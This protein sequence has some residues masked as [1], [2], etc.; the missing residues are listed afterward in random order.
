MV[1]TKQI[2]IAE[3]GRLHLYKRKGA[4]HIR[5]SVN[6]TGKIR[7][8]LPPWVP[9]SAG[10]AFAQQKSDWLKLQVR[11]RQLLRND[12]PVG[13]LHR[14]R[15]ELGTTLRSRVTDNEVI[16]KLP[17]GV[18]L[19]SD[20]AQQAA[21]KASIKA[22]KS[23]AETFLPRRLR[24][25]AA[26]HGFE[27]RSVEVKHLKSRWG[28]CSHR[29]EIVLNCFLMQ[30]PWGLIDYVLLHELM[31]TR[32]MAHGPLFWSELEAYVPNLKQVRREM[33]ARQPHFQI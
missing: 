27:F 24:S 22:L 17:S 16:I 7:V 15:F 29:Q 9:Y 6:S 8:T 5:L 3:L 25:I 26:T 19:D 33:R 23:E 2:E 20:A 1:A 32:I 31:H 21:L 10:I 11:P 30:L 18:R 4:R 13:K 14:L 12:S 28:S